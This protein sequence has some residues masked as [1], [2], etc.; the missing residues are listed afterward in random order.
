MLGNST[1]VGRLSRINGKLI[2]FVVSPTPCV[3]SYGPGCL[4]CSRF[5]PLCSALKGLV[6]AVQEGNPS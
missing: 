6:K 5:A 1:C 3:F 2:D 4:K